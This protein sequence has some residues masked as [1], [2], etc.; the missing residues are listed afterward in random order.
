MKKC[1][2]KKALV[3]ILS[4]AMI[5]SV[6]SQTNLATVSAAKKNVGLNTTF[7][8]LKVGKSYKLK[9]KNNT[10]NWKIKRV[11]TSNKKICTVY[12]KK[13]TSV[14]LKGKSAGKATIKI[15][16]KTNKRKT[17]NTKTLK[18]R[19][20]VIPRKSAPIPEPQP[21]P[22]PI[23][24][25]NIVFNTN[26]GSY[27]S[28]QTVE[29]G[30]II[31]K[32]N[33]PTR[34]GYVF[35]GWYSD[36]NLEKA[37]D[38][39]SAVTQNITLYAKWN[40]TYTV[41]F[42][43]NGGN[44][45]KDQ[46]IENGD[47]VTKPIDPTRSKSIF[48][49]WFSDSQL[50]EKYDFT[51]PVTKD[52]TIYARWQV[53]NDYQS[54]W[55]YTGGNNTENDSENSHVIPVK[56]TVKFDS[57]G[58]SVIDDQIIAVGNNAIKPNDPI[59]DGFVFAG[60]YSD[61]EL[62]DIYDF[63][64]NVTSNITLYAKWNQ[65]ESFVTRYEWISSLL[66][67]FKLP[68]ITDNQHSFDDY[69]EIENA[70]KIE[71]SIRKGILSLNSD[72]DNMVYFKPQ[73]KATREFVAYTAI[74]ALEYEIEKNGLPQWNDVSD[75]I[76]PKEDLL[77]V[78]A[79]I[80]QIENNR[81]LPNS[82]LTKSEMENAIKTIKQILNKTNVNG[83][84]KGE[85]KYVDGIQ[86]TELIYTLD[87]DNSKIDIN[88]PDKVV[89]W[90]EGEIHILRS[91]DNP[92][93]DIAIKVKE[94][95]VEKGKTI[96]TYDAPA[97]EE[98]VTSFDVSGMAK[99]EGIFIPEK[100]VI[101]DGGMQTRAATSGELPLFGKKNIS[102]NSGD[103]SISG[104]IDFKNIEY[105]FVASPSWH[106]I[107]IDEI[108]LAL[109]SSLE[110]NLKYA[111]E[112]GIEE[113]GKKKI[114]SF[115]DVPLGYGFFAS[116]D[117]NLI[118][119]AGGGV[120]VG[121]ELMQ[122]SG[123]Q[124]SKNNGI[125]PVY[126]LDISPKL[127]LKAEVKGG[128]DININANFLKCLTIVSCGTEAGIAAEGTVE[129]ISLNPVQICFDATAY[130][131][132][133]IYAQIGDDDLLNL[134]FDQEILNRDNSIL[135]KELHFEETGLVEEC[136]RGSGDYDGYVK[137]ADN[138][139]PIH[140]AKIQIIQNNRI[141]DTTYTDSH[142]YFKGIKLKK[143]SYKVR[144]CASGYKPYEQIFQIIGGQTTA[145]ETQLMISNE[146]ELEGRTCSGI[147]TDA[148][149]GEPVAGA[150][151]TVQSKFLFGNNDMVAQVIS[152]DDGKYKFHAPIGNYELTV[153]KEGYVKNI[154]S[155]IVFLNTDNFNI[156]LSPENQPN[157]G[158]NLRMVL[159]W[160]IY[161]EDIDSHLV[162]SE[163]ENIFHI[164]FSNM[165]A[166]KANLDVDDVDS[167]GPETITVTNTANGIYSYYVHDYTNKERNNS[168]ELSKS[169]AYVKLYS[170]NKL[171]Y[172]INI[173]QNK[174]GTV[175]HVFD[176][177]S[178][179]EKIELINEFSYEENPDLVGNNSRSKSNIS[180][181]PHK[182]YETNKNK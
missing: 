123:I 166:E 32:P 151:I 118:F 36:V 23:N 91:N 144:V 150:T 75:L 6:V 51:R 48:V 102:I 111:K 64:K 119:K 161:P 160:G 49:D 33:D 34:Q 18:C 182:D 52:M 11:S 137:C 9:L 103:I 126:D 147:I 158:D 14:L 38:F 80:L 155:I 173:P 46:V 87:E 85:I 42:Q 156:S 134:R 164:Y 8:T 100:D 90:K 26:G 141:K 86:E 76:Y 7:K 162:A 98:V 43:T 152:Q 176:Y 15:K 63:T 70:D 148:Y 170:G 45:V 168:E 44:Q 27:I 1:F 121:F 145:L 47:K 131:F 94:I 130:L 62:N 81:F 10:I 181:M 139:V 66:E 128:L 179:T 140:H 77:A 175:W 180:D 61:T 159:Q 120:E 68:K 169:G 142:G 171:L 2:F 35:K 30:K 50:K 28:E 93:N 16:V 99:S 136:T 22:N 114:G 138:N 101:I 12:K 153:Q 29:S 78:N 13:P 88:E 172:T 58:G 127:A 17:L 116:G 56:Y 129:N 165:N 109:N 21:S 135:K 117:V 154:K 5:I 95:A 124:Y 59:K 167:Y 82:V 72:E 79:G 19:V 104:S 174:S 143:G 53:E 67:L 89:G 3:G 163:G 25:Y 110:L 122:K 125:R 20:K 71:A 97:L 133:S 157:V 106:L 65:N 40:N 4:T 149:T 96:I 73:E 92:Q 107:T 146:D 57:N 112:K 83:E 113:N 37:Y 178:E 74:H 105:R 41:K 69:N 177:N 115:I 108:Y 84:N 31:V 54:N 24:T 60:W 55:G 39:S 132:L